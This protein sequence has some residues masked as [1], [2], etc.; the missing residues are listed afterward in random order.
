[1]VSISEK[2]RLGFDFVGAEY[3]REGED[4]NTFRFL[5]NGGNENYRHLRQSEIQILED[6]ANSCTDWSNVLVQ[7]PF[8]PGVISRSNFFGLVRLGAFQSEVLSFHDYRQSEGILS[9]TIISCDVGSHSSISHCPFISNYIIKEH[10]ILSRLDELQ[11]TNH[12]KFG[13]GVVKEGEAPDVL[14]QIDVMN[15]AGGRSVSPFAG[16]TTGDAF[17]WGS[18]R[19]NPEISRRFQELTDKVCDSRRGHYGVIGHDS[20]IK[21]SRIIKDCY[22]GPCTYIKGANKLKNLSILSVEDSPVQIGE[23]VELVNGIIGCGSSVFYGCKA[24]KFVMGDNCNLKY[25]ARLI[26]SILGDNSTVSCC[27]VLNNLVF[28]GHEQHHNNSFLIASLVQGQSN[29]AAGATVGSNHNSRGA[30]GE[31]VA[32]RGF[33]PALSSTLKHNSKFA[34]YTLLSKGNYPKELFVELPFSLIND[35]TSCHRREIMPAFWWMYNMYALERNSYKYKARDKRKHPRQLIET[36]YLAPDTSNEIRKARFLLSIWTAKS[37]LQKLDLNNSN[38]FSELEELTGF[39]LCSVRDLIILRETQTTHAWDHA[40]EKTQAS[41]LS[42]VQIGNALLTAH[43]EIVYQLEVFGEDIENSQ[44]PV[45]ILKPVEAYKAYT[46]MLYYYGITE[47]SQYCR[48]HSCT[49]RELA[50]TTQA[51]SLVNHGENRKGLYA[52]NQKT[53]QIFWENVGGQLIPSTLVRSLLEDVLSGRLDSW[54]DVH[55]RYEELSKAY[56]DRKAMDAYLALCSIF[57]EKMLT[58]EQ[59]ETARA[60]AVRARDYIDKQVFLTKDKDYRNFFRTITYRSETEQEAVIGKLTDNSFI[61]STKAK[62]DEVKAL[63][64]D[65]K[66]A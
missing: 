31:L 54:D 8:D 37:Y 51:D 61:N 49:F 5:E 45:L 36:A 28:P 40:D 29:M 62:S 18:Y 52:R 10:C 47:A 20:V 17:L 46:S 43:P 42:L 25:G 27:E 26:H 39:S 7:D 34:S 53:G 9:S 3:L 59:F 44:N 64:S 11:T 24:V 19:A 48:K 65:M 60:E 35:N 4:E 6:N 56:P 2:S 12:A 55:H 41:L 57:S 63:I 14:V 1:M 33:W 32:G 22:I 38:V 30:D 13:N 58:V 21:G 23:G 15:E 66:F 16:I 50:E